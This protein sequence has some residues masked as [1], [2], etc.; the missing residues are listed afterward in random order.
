MC[1]VFFMIRICSRDGKPND[2][3][4]AHQSLP[5]V[6][7]DHVRSDAEVSA[8]SG[9]NAERERRE[10]EGSTR[11]AS[12]Q[13]PWALVEQDPGFRREDPS[14][15]GT[16]L[17]LSPPA[18]HVTVAKPSGDLRFSLS[19]PLA[20]SLPPLPAPCRRLP[21]LAVL[22]DLP[23]GRVHPSVRRRPSLSVGGRRRPGLARAAAVC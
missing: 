13:R 17:P 2:A 12:P 3:D 8:R 19:A 14:A 23:S 1:R 4:A 10:W 21:P 5:Q 6:A 22:V 15:V 9:A 20:G 7:T 11:Q 18:V 16:P